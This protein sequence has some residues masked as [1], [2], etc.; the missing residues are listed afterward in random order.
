MGI[1][2]KTSARF[3]L[4]SIGINSARNGVCVVLSGR[5]ADERAVKSRVAPVY[6]EIAK[7][8]RIRRVVK[9]EVTS[10][11]TAGYGCETGERQ[12]HAVPGSSGCGCASGDSHTGP[13]QTVVD[14][15]LNL[16]WPSKPVQL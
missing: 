13:A 11:Q 10:T 2:W 7:R 9:L 15:D 12:W 8:M 4:Q 6:P 5:A 1:G 14:L 16:L 3:A